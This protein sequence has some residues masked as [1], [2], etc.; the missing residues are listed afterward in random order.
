MKKQLQTS[1]KC[2]FAAFDLKPWQVLCIGA[3]FVLVKLFLSRAQNVLLL[4]E[5]SFID[6]GLMYRT[7]VS[8]SSGEWLGVYDELTLSKQSFFALWLA[9]LH[10]LRVP[11]LLGGQLLW[12]GASAAAAG[13]FLPAVKKRWAALLLFLLLL[14]CPS[15]LA[16]PA[17]YGFVARVYRDN[18]FP[19]LCLLCVAGMAAFAL[20]WRENPLK[21]VWWLVLAGAGLGAAML[22]RED[23]WWLL[24]FAVAAAVVTLLFV[25]RGAG[26]LGGQKAAKVACLFLPFALMAAMN[27]GWRGMNY[28]HYGRFITTDFSN[29]E[30][31]D[32]YGALTRIGHENWDPKV[33]VPKDVRE[34]VYAASP[35]F[36]KLQPYLE[37]DDYYNRYV[38]VGDYSSGALYWAIRE[39][40]AKIGVYAT[41]Q[42]AESYFTALAAEVNALCDGGALA[43]AG[44]RSSVSPP[45]KAAYIGPVLRETAGNLVYCAT[46]QGTDPRSLFSP[47]GND[48]EWYPAWLEPMEKYLGERAL[49]SLVAGTDT[50]YYS[51]FQRTAYWVLDAV[52]YVY[53]LLAPVA[54]LAALAWQVMACVQ[55]VKAA[56]GKRPVG[57]GIRCTRGSEA[58][59][60]GRPGTGPAW[61]L[62]ITLLGILLC[63]VLRAAMIAYVDVSSF[64]I[65]TYVMYL[66]SI[67]PLLVVYSF[68]GTFLLVAGISRQHRQTVGWADGV[69]PVSAPPGGF[70]CPFGA[71]HRLSRK[72]NR[73]QR[74]FVVFEAARK[75][76]LRRHTVRPACE[77]SHTRG[78]AP[79]DIGPRGHVL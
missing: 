41:P 71:I 74:I 73:T 62:W 78:H 31:A 43:A 5:Q 53:A 17:P 4:A 76:A 44:P 24:P 25:L 46:F 32:A 63:M 33:D 59:D 58:A 28:A 72:P 45:L 40:A 16:N 20:R 54:F 61:M 29:G 11:F 55:M 49:T 70:S 27:L 35:E 75:V 51:L 67:H 66:A 77:I 50:P 52:R 8:I 12:A 48:P 36:A 57:D 23:G 9:F 18:I 37:S 26:E 2:R 39:A 14:F 3:L 15:A 69:S 65:G 47:G 19:A 64:T 21:T 42:T 13:A 6:D 10:A 1:K 60:T 56:R 22:T 7:A 79:A 38:G 30:F 34:K 68:V